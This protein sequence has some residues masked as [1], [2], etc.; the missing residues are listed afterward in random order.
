MPVWVKEGHLTQLLW[1]P[2]LLAWRNHRWVSWPTVIHNSRHSA[3][4][5]TWEA[6][7]IDF[8]SGILWTLEVTVFGLKELYPTTQS[9]FKGSNYSVMNKHATSQHAGIW[10]PQ[11]PSPQAQ[12]S[13]TFV[14]T[15]RRRAFAEGAH[16]CEKVHI[17][18]MSEWILSD[19]QEIKL[20]GCV[21]SRE[22]EESN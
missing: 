11:G 18:Q 5:P 21:C 19:P 14:P 22:T 9:L 1:K 3:P 2:C 17:V 16:L 12:A 6:T 8:S 15:A 20:P 4:S 13:D 10:G 7:P